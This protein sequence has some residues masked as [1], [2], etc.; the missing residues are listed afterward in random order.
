MK[1]ISM[2]D[3]VIKQSL[4]Q[5]T[6]YVAKQRE[7]KNTDN[8]RRFWNC[9]RYAKFLKQIPCLY[10]FVPCK[11]IN[12]IWVALEEPKR[13]KYPNEI[14]YL[15]DFQEYKQAKELVLFEGFE[16][17]KTNKGIKNGKIYDRVWISEI[18]L[19]EMT[20]EDLIKYNLEL[21]PAAKKQ[22]NI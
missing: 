4:I 2:T 12:G 13:E 3:Y 6:D 8:I 7:L 22:F 16:Y 18:N 20:I 17:D 14:Y 19:I 21:T 9:E 1:L 10:M 5:M 15:T 11:F